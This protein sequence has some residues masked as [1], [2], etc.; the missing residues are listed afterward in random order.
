[1]TNPFADYADDY[2][3]DGG[4]NLMIASS[5]FYQGPCTKLKFFDKT[6]N[7]FSNS[8]GTNSGYVDFEDGADND[9]EMLGIDNDNHYDADGDNEIDNDNLDTDSCDSNMAAYRNNSP[10]DVDEQIFGLNDI[11]DDAYD[12]N[13]NYND[14][15][16]ELITQE[17]IDKSVVANAPTYL[18]YFSKDPCFNG[19]NYVNE[20]LINEVLGENELMK[21]TKLELIGSDIC[22]LPERLAGFDWVEILVI[23]NTKIKEIINL[24][25]NIVELFIEQNDLEIFDASIIPNSVLAL[26]FTSNKTKIVTGLKNGI[27]TLNLAFNQIKELDCP[28]PPSVTDLN[29]SENKGFDKLPMFEFDGCN[30]RILDVSGTRISNIDDIPDN[31][32]ILKTCTC[33][34]LRT[35]NKLPSCLTK[36]VAFSSQIEKITCEFPP[37]IDHID[38]YDCY[39]DSCPDFPD[40]IKTI[41]I[42]KNLLDKIPR[43]PFTI[44]TMDIRENDKLDDEDIK[45]L[46]K[47]MPSTASIFSGSKHMLDS[48]ARYNVMFERT[49]TFGDNTFGNNWNM[50]RRNDDSVFTFSCA[51]EF[52]KSNPHYIPIKKQYTL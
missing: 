29:L 8:Y 11:C 3:Y 51:S 35:V 33:T 40:S 44:E 10:D 41:D 19:G 18:D 45:T 30:L 15:P 22:E 24:P 36:W 5:E 7:K 46:E 27:V 14:I 37:Q 38:L 48:M 49:D 6:P 39:L 26:K 32:T 34:V 25:K 31:I 4:E 21:E 1:M 2:D 50:W 12:P 13:P 43:V 9:Y 52:K 28:I 42:G 23:R 20:N 17:D 47:S 16:P